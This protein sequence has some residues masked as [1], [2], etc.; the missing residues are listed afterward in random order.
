MK[1]YGIDMQGSFKIQ[2]VAS[3]PG[4]TSDDIG[5]E[6]YLT[7]N[8]KRYY[9]NNSAWIE[10]DVDKIWTYQDSAPT[11]WSIVAGTTDSLLACKGG[12]DAYN[13][14]GGAQAGTWTQPTHT[15]TGASHIH[16]TAGHT[17]VI[18]EMPSHNHNQRQN[19]NE[20]V[21]GSGERPLGSLTSSFNTASTGG[22][23]SHSHGDTGA[24]SPGT[25]SSNGTPNTYRPV[26]NIGIVIE[27]N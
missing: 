11:G 2:R 16:T 20:C 10:T 8:N 25:G 12:A 22:G 5:R 9:G 14:A 19:S 7:T 15:H 3:L 23:G 17:L 21:I 4:W 24:T 6:V 18:S 1:N 26:A 13:I 27:R